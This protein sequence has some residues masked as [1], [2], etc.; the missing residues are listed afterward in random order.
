[1][2]DSGVVD[3]DALSFVCFEEV[4]HADP[5]VEWRRHWKGW[6]L[7]QVLVDAR[8]GYLFALVGRSN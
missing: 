8:V 3:V 1:M 7:R 4:A 2:L 5:A 6:V